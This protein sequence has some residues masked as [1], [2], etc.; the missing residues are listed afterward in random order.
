MIDIFIK[1]QTD[2]III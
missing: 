2:R 1:Y